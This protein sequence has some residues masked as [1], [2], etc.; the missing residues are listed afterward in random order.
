VRSALQNPEGLLL[1]AVSADQC[2]RIGRQEARGAGVERVD[3][4]EP[5][6]TMPAN[7][8]AN[9]NGFVWRVVC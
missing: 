9:G 2:D 1:A 5:S 6:D 3:L 8:F 4:R 7:D